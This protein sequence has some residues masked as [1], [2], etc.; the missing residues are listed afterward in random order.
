MSNLKQELK[1]RDEQIKAQE[2]HK[3]VSKI[4]KSD[5]ETNTESEE[6]ESEVQELNNTISALEESIEEN[7]D[8]TNMS[9]SEMKKIIEDKEETITQLKDNSEFVENKLRDVENEKEKLISTTKVLKKEL[10]SV[11][12]NLKDDAVK[13]QENENEIKTLKSKYAASKLE[14]SQMVSLNNQL[15]INKEV[16]KKAQPKAEETKGAANHHNISENVIPTPDQTRP[17]NPNTSQESISKLCYSEVREKGSCRKNNCFFSHEIPPGMEQQTML[18]IIGQRNLCINEFNRQGS[19]RKRGECR[20]HHDITAEQRNNT[21]IQELMKQKQEKMRRSRD[22]FPSSNHNLCVYE[23][24]NSGGCPWGE[25][26]K[27]THEITD[28]Q[29]T[30]TT[31]KTMMMSKLQQIR[32]RRNPSP[33]NNNVR[34]NQKQHQKDSPSNTLQNVSATQ[35]YLRNGTDQQQTRRSRS[36][37]GN[38]RKNVQ[39]DR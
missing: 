12:K 6:K 10:E 7:E 14:V 32:T 25:N 35:Q 3:N 4:V 24:Q 20:F 28:A 31:L 33:W 13:L 16:N 34:N 30:D 38:S 9:I 15:K 18:N 23:F 37:R 22:N 39:D 1:K 2:L 26:C 36:S 11:Q 17:E 21:F 27:F 8:R 29:K 5:K 19:C